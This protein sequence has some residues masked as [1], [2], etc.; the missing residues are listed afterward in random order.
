MEGR[1]ILTDY[2]EQALVASVYEELDDGT[3]LLPD[4]YPL[5]LEYSPLEQP[6]GSVRT[7][8]GQS[9]RSGFYSVLNSA[10][11]FL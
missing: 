7:N 10:I 5:A 4:A 11:P 9:W 2:V 6:G 1:F 3:G 8:Y